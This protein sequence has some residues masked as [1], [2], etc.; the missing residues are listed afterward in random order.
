MILI[1]FEKAND[2]WCR[3]ISEIVYLWCVHS[4]PVISLSEIVE[5]D[6]RSIVSASWQHNTG[7]AV[8]FRR[9]PSTVESIAH[10]QIKE[11]NVSFN[12][13]SERA[14]KVFLCTYYEILHDIFSFK[15]RTIRIK[16]NV[17]WLTILVSIKFLKSS[18]IKNS[19]SF[20]FQKRIAR[21]FWKLFMLKFIIIRSFFIGETQDL[22]S[23]TRSYQE[24]GHQN[25]ERP[26]YFRTEWS[27]CF[28]FLRSFI[29]YR[30]ARFGCVQILHLIAKRRRNG[31]ARQ[32]THDRC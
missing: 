17:K 11:K 5:N 30:L 14:N 6:A 12:Q 2:Y 29:G 28:G 13:R 27:W 22:R 23:M 24:E 31:N 15:Y 16:M 10:L 1:W 18:W 25:C 20:Q 7:G 3:N 32:N 21:N 8:G 9:N 26:S 19:N 4:Q